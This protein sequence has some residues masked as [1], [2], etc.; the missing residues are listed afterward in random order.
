MN[1]FMFIKQKNIFVCVFGMSG[2]MK[3]GESGAFI[4]GYLP[5]KSFK[6][7]RKQI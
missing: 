1:H 5:R 4:K 7:V 3:I 6:F 2:E